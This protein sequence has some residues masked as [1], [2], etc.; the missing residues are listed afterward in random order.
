MY[1]M[2][3]D[4]PSEK[5]SERMR[6][7]NSVPIELISKEPGTPLPKKFETFWPSNINKLLLEKL[8]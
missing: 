1:D 4:A 6:C 3:S 7:T 5:D 8:T 2:C